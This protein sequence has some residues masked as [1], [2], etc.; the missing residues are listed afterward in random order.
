MLHELIVVALPIGNVEDLSPRARNII[1]SCDGVLAEDTR[2]FKEFCSHAGIKLSVKV[3]SFNSIQ[4]READSLKLFKQLEGT[5]ILVSDA[6]TPGVNDPGSVIIKGA[7][8]HGIKVGAIPGPSA[9][10]MAI[11]YT[12][13]YGLPAVFLG[14]PPKKTKKDFFEAHLSA[15][16]LV[17][18]LSTHEVLSVLKELQESE[19]FKNANLFILRELTK[20]HEEI[21]EGKVLELFKELSLRKEANKPL[22]E[23]TLVLES[24][25]IVA[26]NTALTPQDLLEIRLAPPSEA[27]RKIAKLSG[28]SREEAYTMLKDARNA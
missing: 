28:I 4:E 10:T 13:G 9:L 5:W 23:M 20:T 26:K 18:F 17:F 11:Q 6:G 19:Y 7:R 16:T 1:E 22:G 12:G 3:E 25:G 27:A 24:P 21:L 14:F 8:H 15:R 2:K